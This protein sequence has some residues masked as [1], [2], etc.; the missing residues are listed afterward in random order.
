MATEGSTKDR[1][2]GGEHDAVDLSDSERTQF[3]RLAA[4]A[5]DPYDVA[6][7][8][9]EGDKPRST[10]PDVTGQSH[11]AAHIPGQRGNAESESNPLSPGALKDKEGAGSALGGGAGGALDAIAGAEGAGNNGKGGFKYLNNGPKLKGARNFFKKHRKKL[12]AGGLAGAGL[13]PII[14]LILFIALA[15]KMPNFVANIAGWRFARLTRQYRASVN[16]IME[17][18]N[19]IDALPDEDYTRATQRYGRFRI[20]DR[21]NRLK[22]NRVLQSLEANDKV[23]YEYRESRILGRQILTKVTILTDRAVN[24]QETVVENGKQVTRTVSKTLITVDVPQSTFSG[25]FQRIVHPFQ[26]LDQYK[27]VIDSLDAAMRA[28]D[29]KINVLTRTLVTKQVL[30]KA[31]ASL[32]GLVAAKYLGKTD[33]QAKIQIERDTYE[34]VNRTGGINGMVSESEKGTAQAVADAEQQAVNS[35]TEMQQL[36]NSGNDVPDS[37]DKVVQDALTGESLQGT[38]KKVASLVIGF[39]NPLYDIAVPVCMVYDGSRIAPQT[40]DAK[41]DS[42]VSEAAHT[43][44]VNDQMQNGMSFTSVMANAMNWKLGNTQ[45]TNVIRRASGKPINTLEGTGGQRTTIGTYGER[46]ILDVFHLGFANDAADKMCPALTNVWLGLGVGIANVVLAFFSGGSSAAGEAGIKT[47]AQTAI[48]QMVD[49]VIKNGLKKTAQKSFREG[50]RFAKQFAK[51]A[52]KF[53]LAVAGATFLAS[54][55]VQSNAGVFNSGLER[56]TAFGDNVDDG[57][58]QLSS[59]MY[60][61]NFYGRPMNNTENAQVHLA[62]HREMAY[63]NSHLSTF[64]RYFAFSNPQSLASRTV[65]TTSSLI[66]RSIFASLLNGLANL[67]N[68]V[69][70]TSKLFAAA[71]TQATYAAGTANTQDYGNVVWGYSPAEE[72]LMQQP[73]YRSPSENS[74]ILD[75][76]GKRDEI[77]AKYS[78]CYN[79]TIGTLLESKKI[80]RSDDTGDVLN[81]GDCSPEQLGTNNPTYGDLVFRWRLE[82][83]YQNTTDALLNIQDPTA[84]QSST[85]AN[86]GGIPSGTVQQLASQILHNGNISFQSDGNGQPIDE[87]AAMQHIADTGHGTQCGA[88]AVSPILLG[89]VLALAQKYKIVLGVAV[90]GHSC[91]GG[92]HPKGMAIDINGVTSMDGSQK[93]SDGRHISNSDYKS[94]NPILL[95]FYNDAGKLLDQSGGGGLGQYFCWASLPPKVSSKVQYFDDSCDHLHMDVGKR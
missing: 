74:Y 83:N 29:P 48:K 66:N 54:M 58:S 12:I 7:S 42:L 25:R 41:H 19:A 65:L 93:T 10:G 20:F 63:Y 15:L 56:N 44:A 84:V 21:V 27:T 45:D 61:Q 23:K 71:N 2:T 79:Q 89:V 4:S 13:V 43:M 78:A 55:L 59:D 73:T 91:N 87:R 6:G 85:V 40:V 18:K 69:G 75:K 81:E 46:T 39:I 52:G 34:K 95:S 57:A 3:D 16:N 50:G 62:D 72:A 31:G 86:L 47:T 30:E 53:T 1:T 67:F 5:Q 76:S 68:P 64:E 90:D 60:A 17:E 9:Y 92:F 8:E 22:P 28:H 51:D 24:V 82:H 94:N 11:R 35:D 37:V 38:V 14:A 26:T 49:R 36:V 88:P 77:E 33:E 32:K 80:V 70:L